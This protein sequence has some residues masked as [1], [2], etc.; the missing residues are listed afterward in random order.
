MPSR[1]RST[2]TWSRPS[3]RRSRR[4]PALFRGLRIKPT[5]EVDPDDASLRFS[6]E[7]GRARAAGID[8]TIEKLLEL[9]GQDR[10]RAQETD[11]AD[12]RRV[13]G[14][15]EARLA[16]PEPDARG[17]PDPARGRARLPG[18]QAPRP[19]D[20]LQ[21]QE[22]ALL[23]QR[24]T[25]RDRDD[26]AEEVRLLHRSAVRGT[27]NEG[28][29]TRR[30]T[31]LLGVTGG[32]PYG[33]QELA[34]FVWGQVP[35][36][37]FA[38]LNDVEWALTQVLR[39]EHNHFARIWDDATHNERLLLIALAQEPA[40]AYG[41]DYRRRHDLPSPSHVQRAAGEL[42][43][44]EVVG[45]EP[46]GSL[47]I[48]EPF[49]AEWVTREQADYGVASELQARRPTR[50]KGQW[51]LSRCRRDGS[52]SHRPGRRPQLAARRSRP[53]SGRRRAR[54]R[55]RSRARPASGSRRSGALPSRLRAAGGC[56]C[57]PRGRPSRSARSRT[58][59]SATCS[60]ESLD[61]VLPALT[62]PRRRALEVALLVEDAAGRPV[63]PR[64]LG[65]AVRN[66]L[67]LLAEDGLVVAIDDLQ[68]LDASSASALGFALRRL[69][70][71]NVLLVW[72]R[73]L[74]E[75][76]QPSAVENALDQDRIDHVRVGPLSVGA[77]QQ[78]LHG[79]LDRTLARPT[80]L[81]LHEA[82]GGNPFY[83]LELAR[84]LG[85]ESAVR[86]PTQPLPVPERLEELVSARLDGFTGATH[87][88]LVLASAHARLTVAELGAR[89]HRAE[90]TRAGAQGT[91][92]RARAA[93]PFGSR[94]RCSPRS[95]TRASP[96]PSGSVRTAASRSSSTIRSRG[97]RHLALSTD[98]PDAELA[99]A[100]ER[101]AVA[102]ARPGRV[103][104]RSRARRARASSDAG[105]DWC[106][107]R[108]SCEG[109]GSNPSRGGRGRAS[110]RAWQAI[111]SPGLRPVQSVPRRW[112]SWPKSSRRSLDARFR[113]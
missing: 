103:D 104:G 93:A 91:G 1:R 112:P 57:S 19:R 27:P 18:Q 55:S 65:V 23:A 59:A 71:A 37:H 30:S 4:P 9:P 22:R 8:E 94:T 54:S 92:D 31:R 6:F 28:S 20:D 10:R 60:T 56:V 106:R 113:C 105:G 12:L 26:P 13:P 41:E 61:D 81:R 46:K 14:G 58:P 86:D 102:A 78:L 38:T 100:L 32:H 16:V 99:A 25:G 69:P 15:A 42:V 109:R 50:R 67:E 82:S 89:G 24:E 34:Y 88:A 95:S 49:F 53:A 48:V 96:P 36:G 64:A 21:R 73:R 107:R 3:V 2:K 66:A 75:G 68:W 33:T 62:A 87:E 35:K 85:S 108:S 72:T 84:A 45:R 110:A 101:A 77:I 63:D 70:E 39:S 111:S 47:R 43:K 40:G 76:E 97:A 44:E 11:G 83:A 17:L 52:R 29:A 98:R 51:C 7:T 5:I 90:C 79:R 74:G 80:L